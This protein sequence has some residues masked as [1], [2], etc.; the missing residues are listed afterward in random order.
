MCSHVIIACRAPRVIPQLA[1]TSQTILAAEALYY[2]QFKIGV[3]YYIVF[4][5]RLVQLENLHTKHNLRE[6]FITLPGNL[7]S[8]AAMSECTDHI[9]SSKSCGT[10]RTSIQ[11]NFSHQLAPYKRN[12]LNGCLRQS[13]RRMAAPGTDDDMNALDAAK[14]LALNYR[15]HIVLGLRTLCMSI[16]G[17]R[18][19]HMKTLHDNGKL[20]ENDQIGAEGIP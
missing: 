12:N 6:Q 20:S 4:V 5:A 1:D 8:C 14:R 9:P 7:G 10:H 15:Q 19:R 18:S 13:R 2:N 17:I 3:K 11:S 16:W